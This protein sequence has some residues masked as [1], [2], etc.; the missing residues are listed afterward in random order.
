MVRC[1]GE[2]HS[3]QPIRLPLEH[4]GQLHSR[5]NLALYYVLWG[6]SQEEPDTPVEHAL[7]P[8]IVVGPRVDSHRGTF[9]CTSFPVR[10]YFTLTTRRFPGIEFPR[11][12]WYVSSADGMHCNVD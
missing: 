11:R 5:P 9:A 10:G 2:L 4:F 3:E 7:Y 8:G 6:A 12:E 1:Y